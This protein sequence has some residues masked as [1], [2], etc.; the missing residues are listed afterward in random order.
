MNDQYHL[1]ILYVVLH[2][3]ICHI[4]S[5]DVFEEPL[6]TDRANF[7]LHKQIER[8]CWRREL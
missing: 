8:Q 7:P 2:W 3:S 1:K 6:A 4:K 5:K